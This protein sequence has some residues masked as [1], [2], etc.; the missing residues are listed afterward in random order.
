MPITRF[1]DALPMPEKE[2]AMLS[3]IEIP[4]G[5]KLVLGAVPKGAQ[6]PPHKAPYSASIQLLQGSIEVL[7]GETWSRLAPGERI[8][9]DQGQLHGVRALESS[10]ILATHLRGY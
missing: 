4:D 1:Q 8:T 3:L 2:R 5:L 9:F 7:K 6:V 10:Y